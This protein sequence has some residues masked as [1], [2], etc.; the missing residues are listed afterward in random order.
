MYQKLKHG[1]ISQILAMA[2]IEGSTGTMY[3]KLNIFGHTSAQ[4]T[5]FPLPI[6]GVT[7]QVFPIFHG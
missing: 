1:K 3:F 7:V 6:R 4:I 5:V 2:F